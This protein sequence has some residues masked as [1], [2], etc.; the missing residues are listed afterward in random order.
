MLTANGADII[1]EQGCIVI[2]HSI[3]TRLV[4]TRCRHAAPTPPRSAQRFQA[5]SET[6]R[7]YRAFEPPGK[8]TQSPCRLH[9]VETDGT[10]NATRPR[11]TIG[12]NRLPGC[13]LSIRA[14]EE[15]NATWPRGNRPSARLPELQHSWAAQTPQVPAD[16]ASN[17]R[18]RLN[19]PSPPLARFKTRRRRSRRSELEG[20]NQ[21]P[22]MTRRGSRHPSQISPLAVCVCVCGVSSVNQALFGSAR[23]SEIVHRKGEQGCCAMR[24]G[25]RRNTLLHVLDAIIPSYGQ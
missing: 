8:D 11:R 2:K 20:I 3:S 17:L 13:V 16:A 19:P 10:E 4:G 21:A 15:V 18:A 22:A 9:V 23:G 14:L 6:H 1:C 7:L 24:V 12:L 5:E 25:E